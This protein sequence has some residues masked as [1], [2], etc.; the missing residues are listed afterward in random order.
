MTERD[1]SKP[2]IVCAANRN[3]N[4]EIAVG[5]RHLSPTMVEQ[6]LRAL[7]KNSTEEEQE[8][9]RLLWLTAEQGFIDQFGTFYTREEAWVIAKENG[10]IAR[11]VGGDN[12]DRD[13][14]RLFSENLY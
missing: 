11:F 3:K 12:H 9:L 6:I 8:E 1:F 13:K 7:P 10:Q 4:G 5:P 14:G 2:F